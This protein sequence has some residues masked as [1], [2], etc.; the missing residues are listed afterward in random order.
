MPS[1]DGVWTDLCLAP[2]ALGE[3]EQAFRD[4]AI[5][6]SNGIM[7]WIGSQRALPTLYA[8]MPRHFGHGALVTPGL[9]DCHTHLVYGGQRANE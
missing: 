4:A 1:A 9:V 6:V 2:E 3:G 8:S 5:V 7:V